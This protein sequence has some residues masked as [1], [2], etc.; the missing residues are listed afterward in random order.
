MSGM[1]IHDADARVLETKLDA[2]GARIDEGFRAV[3]KRLDETSA[4]TARLEGRI[5]EL[6]LNAAEERAKMRWLVAIVGAVASAAG[7]AL[8][9]IASLIG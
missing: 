4:N 9:K 8:G 5:R 2:L 6:E 1:Q 7:G 3:E